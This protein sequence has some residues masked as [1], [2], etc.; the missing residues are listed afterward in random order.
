[1]IKKVVV[2]FIKEKFIIFTFLLLLFI[3]T[4]LYPSEIVNYPQYV[5]WRTIIAFTGLLIITTGLKESGYF[6]IF[7]I[8]ILNRIKC[9]RSLSIFLI[10]LSAFLS[11]FLTNDVTLFIVIPLTLSMQNLL[12]KDLSKLIV[13]EAISANVGSTLTPIGN[14][15]NLILW[16]KWGISFIEFIAKTFTLVILLFIILLI[17]VWI[18][19]PDRKIKFSE[20]SKGNIPNKKGLFISSL[21]M[22]VVYLISLEVGLVCWVLS[23]IFIFYILFY[24][25]VLLK[26]DWLLLII[27]IIIFIDFQLIA[28]I[29]IVS[30]FIKRLNLHSSGD[31]FLLSALISQLISNVP[32]TVLVLK[33]SNNYLAITYGV[34]VGGNGSVVSSLANIIAL[35]MSKNKEIWLKFHKYSIPYFIVVLI[36]T[37]YIFF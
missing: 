3:L 21:L 36:I 17:F 19:F 32:S 34:N 30:E 26:V 33:F 4:V 25:E 24:R 2:D 28:T 22:L 13:F 16:Q 14:P 1:M 27:F 11:T 6:Y 35:R 12:K 15:Q 29:P 23:A 20:K 18:V 5:D 10:L 7:S 31:I 8:N 9:E 37:Y